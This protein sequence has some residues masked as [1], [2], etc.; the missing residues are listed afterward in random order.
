MSRQRLEQFDYCFLTRDD[1]ESGWKTG[2]ACTVLDRVPYEH[3]IVEMSDSAR[4]R[5]LDEMGWTE[6][7]PSA[8]LIDDTPTLPEYML[9]RALYI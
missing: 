1:P 3:W 4:Q 2:D 5:R 6:D 8:L 9:Q 7:H